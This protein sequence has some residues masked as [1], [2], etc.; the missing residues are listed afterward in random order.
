MRLFN[1]ATQG[2][3]GD[4]EI[5]EN[6]DG[7]EEIQDDDSFGSDE[8]ISQSGESGDEE[9]EDWPP[10]KVKDSF[11]RILADLK[12]GAQSG[13][14]KSGTFDL[15]TPVGVQAFLDANKAV[16]KSSTKKQ[17]LLHL[18]A[19]SEKDDLPP[20]R[21][22]EPLI[23]GLVELSGNLLATQDE[24]GKTP[25][26]CA[27][28]NKNHILANIMCE[29][30]AD[31]NSILSISKNPKVL[32]S[33]NCIHQAIIKKSSAKDVN[34]LK[35]LIERANEDTLLAVDENGLTPLHLAVEYRRCD[36]AQ[37]GIVQKLV[38]KCDKALDMTFKHPEKGLLSPY[39]YHEFTYEEAKQRE[40]QVANRKQGVDTEGAHKSVHF[41]EKD[42]FKGKQRELSK[43]M[44][45]ELRTP[46]ILVPSSRPQS[47]LART[48]GFRATLHMP[49]GSEDF[50]V[51]T[52]STNDINKREKLKSVDKTSSKKPKASRLKPTE[53]SALEIKQH[54]KLEY[55]RKRNHDDA[56]EFLYG[57]QQNRHIYFDLS[58]VSPKVNKS[59]I[60][61]GL[62]HLLLEDILQ[63]VAIPRVE[64]EDDPVGLRPGQRAP[65]PDGNGRTDMKPLFKWL[66]DEK[67]VKIILKVIVD[68]LQ[69]PAHSDEAIEF[70]LIGMGVEIWQWKKVDLSPEVIQKVAPEARI[71]HLYWSGN[72][73]VLR[74]WS[75]PEGLRKLKRLQE[76]HLHVQQGLE[77]RARTR[78]NITAF[79][80]RIENGVIKVYDS[81]MT[82]DTIDG[83]LNGSD[84]IHDPYERHKWISSMEEFADFLQAAERNIEPPLILKHP[85]TIAV[86]DD[87]V[88]INDQSIQSRIIGGRSFCHRDEEQNLNQPYYVSGGGHGTAMAR[89]AAKVCPNVRLYILRLDEYFIEPGRRQITA[90][91]AAK[92]V[93]AAVEKKVD[94]ISMSWTIE[95][96]D[97]NRDDIKKLEDA[98]GLAARQNILMFCAATDQGA[99]KDQTYPA[100]SATKNI[101]KIGAAEA[102]GTALKWLGDQSLVD[103]IFPGHKVV[104]E[105]HDNP[106]VKNY[107]ALTGSSVATALASALAAV[108]LYCVQLAD[109]KRYAGRPNELSAYKSLKDHER[110]KEAFSQ[111]GTTKESDNKYIMVWNRFTRQVKQAEKDSAPRDRYIDYIIGLADELMRKA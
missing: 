80:E 63:Y 73:A 84:A 83:V 74:G 36:E 65:K 107:T 9:D 6:L 16:E 98:V 77:T 105:R 108:I 32:R 39:L 86:I 94:I 96:T 81:K 23:S 85:I 24:N 3:D 97:G 90:K 61:R 109:T 17:T 37:L 34:P 82:D 79:K 46:D 21:K 13:K 103:F 47:R 70:C 22:M 102:S 111:I 75:E 59:G 110:M 71:V 2:S 54:L 67:K 10:K 40:K 35:S 69:E 93:C 106:N 25:L 45:R 43:D 72:N 91:S 15:T 53:S 88:D 19:E 101:F 1:M 8:S 44:P 78:Q 14:I 29:A 7:K 20:A 56:V 11:D 62:G 95:K 76:V 27:I 104:M 92:A 60:T 99:Y 26:F 33:S 48:G 4:L 64:V 52:T 100:A 12:S 51:G 30:H 89:L 58:G 28:S 38:E 57:S 42:N 18:I 31:V 5:T 41:S 49:N 87:G 50:Q 68:D 66:R 55:L